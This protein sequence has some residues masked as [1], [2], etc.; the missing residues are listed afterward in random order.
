MTIRVVP[1]RARDGAGQQDPRPVRSRRPAAGAARRAADRGDLRHRCQ[2]HR[3]RVGPRT[4]AP[5]RSSRSASRRRAV[6]AKPTSREMV[7]D[8]R[9]T[10][11]EDKKRKAQVEAKNHAEALLTF[12]REGFGR[13]QVPRSA[14]PERKAIENAMADLKEALKGDDADAIQ[15]KTNTLGAGFDEARRGDVQGAAGA[16][17][18]WSWCGWSWCGAWRR[19]GQER[20]CRR[21]GVSPRST[22]T[23]RSPPEHT[24]VRSHG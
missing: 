19:A 22:T 9:R 8:A 18:R 5:A 7:K 23:R 16:G 15:A 13:A 4:R 17:R 14:S 1:G 24:G 2:R 21:R 20:G 10:R 6:S 12:H 11:E 3:Q